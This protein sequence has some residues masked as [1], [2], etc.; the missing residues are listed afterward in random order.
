[1]KDPFQVPL[2][3]PFKGI[4]LRAPNDNVAATCIGRETLLNPEM[5]KKPTPA[6]APKP[7][8]KTVVVIVIEKIVTNTVI[9]LMI[10]I[11]IMA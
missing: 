2:R 10:L 11:E 5:V 6:R 4:F 7:N 8:P 9:L 1:M 3:V